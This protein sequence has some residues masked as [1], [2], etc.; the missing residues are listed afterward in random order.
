VLGLIDMLSNI[1]LA[2]ATAGVTGSAFVLGL[3]LCAA[4]RK[5]AVQM[6]ASRCAK[7]PCFVHRHLRHS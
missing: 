1:L 4:A 7:A 3:E 5:Q 6:H 2:V